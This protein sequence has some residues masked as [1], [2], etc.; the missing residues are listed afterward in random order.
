[1]RVSQDLGLYLKTIVTLESVVRSLDPNFSAA[2]FAQRFFRKLW[3]AEA[4]SEL[5][6]DQLALS[7]LAMADDCSTVIASLQT[8]GSQSAVARGT[9]VRLGRRIR[10]SVFV[11]SLMGM[12]ILA[13]KLVAPN[14]LGSLVVGDR[15]LWLI[16]ILIIVSTAVSFSLVD[17]QRLLS[18]T[19]PLSE[20]RERF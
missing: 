6:P 16:P 1:M 5:K 13:L 9:I 14:L 12:F 2:P 11:A 8:F 3:L 17:I 7:Y 10:F 19:R 15:Q 18:R 20:R 4:R